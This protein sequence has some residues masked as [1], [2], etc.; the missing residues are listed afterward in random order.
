MCVHVQ[1]T[2]L[3]KLVDFKCPG[4]TDSNEFVGI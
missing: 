1:N 4:R 2:T 3:L